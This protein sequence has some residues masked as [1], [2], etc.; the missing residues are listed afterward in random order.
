MVTSS[1]RDY[2]ILTPRA[3]AADHRRPVSPQETL[4]H[5]SV[6]VSVRSLGPG[7]HKFFL[8]PLSVSS[9]NKFDSKCEFTP[10]IILLGFSFALGHGVSPH[11]HSSAY[12]LT[13]VSLTWTWVSP[14]SRSS[15]AQ[16][17]LLTLDMGYLFR[18]APVNHRNPLESL[19]RNGVAIIVNK[20]V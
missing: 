15:E 11:S 19:R 13:G 2:D 9:G 8:S 6:S 12:C 7:V 3:P 4:K 1:K 18:T 16:P 10:P 5:S 17:Q 20:R 14:Y